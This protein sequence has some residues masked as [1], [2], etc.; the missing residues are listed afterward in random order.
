MVQPAV[1]R[2]PPLP[3]PV[4]LR[5]LEI[6]EA[7]GPVIINRGVDEAKIRITGAQDAPPPA[8]PRITGILATPEKD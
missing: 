4:R 2:A 1:E 7:G 8:R 3:E 6:T 5:I